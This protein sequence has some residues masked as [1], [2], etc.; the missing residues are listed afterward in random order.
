MY[1]AEQRLSTR[2]ADWSR[3]AEWA[4]VLDPMASATR[5][6]VTRTSDEALRRLAREV[7]LRLSRKA[8]PH[9]K[10]NYESAVT[11]DLRWW[12]AQHAAAASH[13]DEVYEDLRLDYILYEEAYIHYLFGRYAEAATLFRESVNAALRAIDRALD[14]LQ[15]TEETII[16]A[17]FAL[18]NVWVAGLHERRAALR[19]HYCDELQGV[20]PSPGRVT[21]LAEG[22]TATYQALTT[23]LLSG[24]DGLKIGSPFLDAARKTLCPDHQYPNSGLTIDLHESRYADFIRRHLLSAWIFSFET[25]GWSWLFRT[26]TIPI[27]Q[28]NVP[29]PSLD[30]WKTLALL[31]D[32][33]SRLVYRYRQAEL[34]FHASSGQQFNTPDALH[35][36]AML[37]AAGSF[38]HLGDHLLLAWRMARDEG[39]RSA[40]AWFLGNQ[41]PDVGCN[42]LPKLALRQFELRKS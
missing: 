35:V 30:T 16:R 11:D 23:A 40:I 12:E 41:V 42:A 29:P 1:N 25:P 31:S 8:Y 27:F 3:A 22:I 14:P 19:Q 6:L 9:D 33:D 5:H 26:V 20:P 2:C 4:G 18:S 37:R 7:S 10:D 38:E 32:R 13:P 36:A 21:A 24:A 28:P 39:E 15:R 17:K 34:L